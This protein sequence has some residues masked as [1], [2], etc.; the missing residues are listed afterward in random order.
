MI[1]IFFVTHVISVEK[2]SATPTFMAGV[3]VTKLGKLSRARKLESNFTVSVPPSLYA[4]IWEENMKFMH[5]KRMF[6]VDYFEF[7]WKFL[8]LNSGQVCKGKN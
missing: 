5:E 6:D 4:H 2:K 7:M 3:F 8:E 1:T